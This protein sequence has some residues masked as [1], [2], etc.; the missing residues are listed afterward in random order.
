M[1]IKIILASKIFFTP[2]YTQNGNI[3]HYDYHMEQ[4]YF[5]RKYTLMKHHWIANSQ[6]IS[7]LT[8]QFLHVRT[9]I[10]TIIVTRNLN[11]NTT[12]IY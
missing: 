10:P 7:I 3:G 9:Y 5:N 12:Y 2:E 8:F 6:K 1:H 11:S 4:K